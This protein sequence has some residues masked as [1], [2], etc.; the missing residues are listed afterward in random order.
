MRRLIVAALLLCG[1]GA[2]AQEFRLNDILDSLKRGATLVKLDSAD[3][4]AAIKLDSVSKLLRAAGAGTV[5]VS[6]LAGVVTGTRVSFGAVNRWDT[7]GTDLLAQAWF[8]DAIL[9]LPKIANGALLRPLRTTQPDSITDGILAPTNALRSLGMAMASEQGAERLR[10][11]D[12]KYGTGSPQLNVL[13]ATVNFAFQ[14]LPGL[15]AAK[16]GSPSR[17]EFL[18]AYRTLEVNVVRSGRAIPNAELISAG[19]VGLRWYRWSTTPD[20]RWAK[21]LQPRYGSA[22]LYVVGPAR[23]PFSS[24]IRVR[25]RHGAFIGFGHMHLAF[26]AEYPRHFVVGTDRHLIPHLF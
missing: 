22:G 23:A 20:G 8:H 15:R 9:L 6:A 3:P 5:K 24:L 7:R 21:L 14:W 12:I 13:E 18:G 26:V 17:W 1:S 19:Q 2:R 11:M 16:D 4:V 10:R 25:R